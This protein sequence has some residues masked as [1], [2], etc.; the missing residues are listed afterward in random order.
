MKYKRVILVSL[1]LLLMVLVGSVQAST[2]VFLIEPLKEATQN[3]ECPSGCQSIGGNISAVGGNIDFCIT[4]PSGVTVL[5][6]ENISFVDFKVNTAQNGTYVIHLA[7]RLSTN[8]D[9]T[10][11]LFYGKNFYI[12]L[13]AEVSLA[14]ST[15]TALTTTVSSP[16]NPFNPLTG[17]LIQI[18]IFIFTVVVAPLLVSLFRDF[19]LRK[20]QKYKDGE[21]KTPVVSR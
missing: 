15:V 11:I 3:V 2:G 8:N 19:I 18:G 17:L 1:P 5:R 7:N 13:S 20:Y 16:S 10:A 9:V 12:V 4:D 6:Y 14:F 21:S